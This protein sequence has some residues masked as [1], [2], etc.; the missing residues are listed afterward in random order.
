MENEKVQI[1]LVPNGNELVIRHGEAAKVYDPVAV[2]ISGNIK[3]PRKFYDTRKGISNYVDEKYIPYFGIDETH[4][5]V[6]RYAGKI[7]LV[8]KEQ[9]E[10]ATKITGTLSLS[11]EYQ[12]IGINSG[13]SYTP[14][15]LGKMLR[16]KRYL[17]PELEDGMKLVAELMQFTAKVSADVEQK[18]DQRGNKKNALAVAVESNIPLDLVLEV[19]IFKGFAPVKLKIEIVLDSRGHAVDCYLESPEAL[20]TINEEKNK[21][22]D[23]ELFDL[24]QHGITVIEI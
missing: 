16:S 8:H 2:E 7:T 3:A 15:E 12:E 11:P 9:S 21:I 20:K 14:A 23:T 6:D 19:P 5:L 10:F 17:F 22:F 18:Q 24:I 4:V 13:K 1:N